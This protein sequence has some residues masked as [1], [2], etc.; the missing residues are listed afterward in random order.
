MS[1]K[2]EFTRE[3]KKKFERIVKRYPVKRAAML[4][5]LH[6][7]QEQN[8]FISEE[9]E[10]Y[11]SELLEVPVVD[12]REVLSFYSLLQDREMGRHHIRVCRSVSCWLMGAD[13]VASHLRDRLAVESG[14]KTQDGIFSWEVVPDCMGACEVAPMLQM[15]KDY[16]G[17]LTP[18]KI[19]RLLDGAE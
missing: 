3:N 7:A 9:V 19:D 15:D 12:V 6:L 10:R 1:S 4:P 18:D 16:F 13:G 5:T 2:F 17:D 8:G 14:S 11:V